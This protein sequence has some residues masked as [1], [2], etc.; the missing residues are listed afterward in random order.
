[1]KEMITE[2]VADSDVIG[3][4]NRIVDLIADL[5]AKLESVPEEFRD[6]ATLEVWAYDWEGSCITYER[7]I[8]EEE[9]AAGIE[10]IEAQRRRADKAAKNRQTEAWLRNIRIGARIPDRDEAMEFLR[11]SPEA[12]QYHPDVYRTGRHGHA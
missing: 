6:S 5:R 11:T 8:T 2:T 9:I 12:N 1:M 10:S 4:T 7:P 3:S